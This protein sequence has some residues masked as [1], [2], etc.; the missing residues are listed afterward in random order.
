[1]AAFTVLLCHCASCSMTDTTSTHPS[2]EQK[3]KKSEYRYWGDVMKHPAP[4]KYFWHLWAF[5]FSRCS[6]ADRC[7]RGKSINE[8]L[9]SFKHCKLLERGCW[10]QR[11]TQNSLAFT[12]V[13]DAPGKMTPFFQGWKLRRQGDSHCCNCLPGHLLSHFISQDKRHRSVLNR[14][15]IPLHTSCTER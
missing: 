15:F 7:S 12:A 14:T 2:G 13:Y 6:M 5:H 10:L 8:F 3:T 9:S 1:M 11:N 4:Q